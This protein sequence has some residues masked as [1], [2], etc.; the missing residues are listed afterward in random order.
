MTRS[1]R[2][3][4]AMTDQW[5]TQSSWWQI[6]NRENKIQPKLEP[7]GL[8]VLFDRLHCVLFPESLHVVTGAPVYSLGNRHRNSQNQIPSAQFYFLL[9]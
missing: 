9:P 2:V 6:S 7:Q 8:C 4:L 3:G 5:G 1:Q